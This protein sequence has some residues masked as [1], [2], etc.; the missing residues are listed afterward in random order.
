M[1]Q[2]VA[3]CWKI[4]WSGGQDTCACLSLCL[5]AR[6]RCIVL[7]QSVLHCFTVWY[8]MLQGDAAFCS[9]LQCVAVNCSA[10]QRLYVCMSVVM[11]FYGM[12]CPCIGE[13]LTATHCNPLQHTAMLCNALHY[14]AAHCSTL[15]HT[16]THCNMLR[17]AVN[18]AKYSVCR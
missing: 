11:S 4:I 10:M 13:G 7:S 16:A 15:Q 14:T 18:A 8:N 9:V 6:E 2:Y 1:L 12:C 3:V 17:Y 5:C